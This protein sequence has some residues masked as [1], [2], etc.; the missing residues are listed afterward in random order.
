MKLDY[1]YTTLDNGLRVLLHRDASMPIVCVNMAYHVGSSNEQ[2][3]LRGFAHLFEHL[4]FEGS[5]HVPRGKFDFYCE[6]A[7]GFSNAYTSEDKTN[8]YLVLPSNHLET[9]L[10]LESDRLLALTMTGE[11]FETQRDVV[12][13]EKRQRVDN[14]PYGSYDTKLAEM[15]FGTGPYGHPVIGYMEDLRSAG[16]D[17]VYNFHKR[18]YRP[19]N[20]VLSIAGDIDERKAMKMIETWFAPIPNGEAEQLPVKLQ[21]PASDTEV[22]ATIPDA[23]PLPGVFLAWRIP[24]ESHEDFIALDLVSD[25]LGSGESSRLHRSLVYERQIASQVSAW[26]EGREASG[27]LVVYAIANPGRS[28]EQLEAAIDEVI[29]RL[30]DE[31]PGSGEMQKTKNRVEAMFYQSLQSITS[32]ADRFAHYALFYD[33]P[34]LAGSMIDRYMKTGADDIHHA[35][36]RYLQP[37]QRAVLHYV[38]R[39]N[40]GA[41]PSQHDR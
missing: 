25:I 38:P 3:G 37:A 32:R 22:R 23:V 40:G 35:V 34:A 17:A 15:L 11:A 13:E 7:G 39:N 20:A 29:E 27:Q 4:M 10:W 41:P 14:Q 6:Q 19:D 24:P 12:M 18:H 1:T 16:M 8:Y 33:E 28:A 5:Q 26:V 30:I 2:H 21:S 31:G 9:G 36:S